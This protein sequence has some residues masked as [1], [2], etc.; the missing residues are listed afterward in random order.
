MVAG[1]EWWEVEASQLQ[2]AGRMLWSIDVRVVGMVLEGKA[3][4]TTVDVEQRVK[5]VVRGEGY[6]GDCFW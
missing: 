2:P 4:L 3:T 1:S 5:G 6:W